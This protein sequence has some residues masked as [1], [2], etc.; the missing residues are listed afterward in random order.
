MIDFRPRLILIGGAAKLAGGR[1]PH[2]IA[3]SPPWLRFA[4]LMAIGRDQSF[5]LGAKRCADEVGAD[6]TAAKH[7]ALALIAGIRTPRNRGVE[8]LLIIKNASP[9]HLV[10]RQMDIHIAILHEAFAALSFGIGDGLCKSVED[11]HFSRLQAW[12]AVPTSRRKFG[13]VRSLRRTK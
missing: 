4:R 5:F 8:A 7:V 9:Q 3:G 10:R 12:W 1:E 13:S 6:L 11:G 2:R